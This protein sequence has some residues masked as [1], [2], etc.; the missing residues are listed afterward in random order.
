MRRLIAALAGLGLLAAALGCHH[1]AGMC[2]C[3]II[4]HC[5]CNHGCAAEGGCGG[6]A[7]CGCGNG[8]YVTEGQILHAAAAPGYSAPVAVSS[9]TPTTAPVATSATTAPA[10][11]LPAAS[12]SDTTAK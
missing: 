7:S 12:T 11:M 1:T 9:A 2:D 10:K 3:D 6:C 4:S 8:G 5:G